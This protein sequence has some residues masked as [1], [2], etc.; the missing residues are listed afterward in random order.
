L[1]FTAIFEFDFRKPQEDG[2][3]HPAHRPVEFDLLCD[4]DDLQ[5][6]LA[7]I[8]QQVHAVPKAAAKSVKFP[9]DDDLDRAVEDV[10]L[11]LLEGRAVKRLPA[12]LVLIPLDLSGSDVDAFKPL[13]DFGF[14][15]VGLLVATAHPDVSGD[16]H[17]G[18][19]VFGDNMLDARRPALLLPITLRREVDNDK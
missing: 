2:G 15:A 6:T 16:F 11:K 13:L 7:P 10:L 18:L 9:T 14:L 3:D 5:P 12:F 4:D 17:D 8:G 1:A 19:S